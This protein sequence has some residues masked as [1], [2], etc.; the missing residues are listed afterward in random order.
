MAKGVNKTGRDKREHGT[1][2]RRAFMEMPAYRALS[3]K[4]QILYLWLKLEWKGEKYNN[5]NN[6]RIRL[7]LRQAAS[8]I[9]IGIN[10]AG[11]AF[12]DLQAKGFIVCTELG[13]LGVTGE[14]RGPSFELT[15]IV[16]P[17]SGSHVGSMLYKDW[18]PGH[19]FPVARHNVNNPSGRN[20]CNVPSSKA[21]RSHLQNRDD[22]PEPVIET[23]TPHHRKR[24]VQAIG[25]GGT[26]IKLKTSLYAI[27]NGSPEPPDLDVRAG[28]DLCPLLARVV[29]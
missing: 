28:L 9:G 20:G 12:H 22:C 1:F 23:V 3:A 14:A 5:N 27:P 11:D 15:E 24:D 21:G 16:M 18:Q 29:G 17:G 2:V 25:Q 19:D 10:A 4:A 13:A 8:R 7:S 6:G 26:V